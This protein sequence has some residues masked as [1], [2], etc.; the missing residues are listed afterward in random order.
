MS[1]PEYRSGYLGMSEEIGRKLDALPRYAPRPLP[2]FDPV[3]GVT[4]TNAGES[5]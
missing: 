1:D 2:K 3:V 4:T 5:W